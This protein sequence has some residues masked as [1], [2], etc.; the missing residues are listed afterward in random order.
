LLRLGGQ[1]VAEIGLCCCCSQLMS[2]AGRM[3]RPG[4]RLR[5]VPA[6][7][8]ADLYG[9]GERPGQRAAGRSTRLAGQ[10]VSRVHRR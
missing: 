6:C 4:A 9:H 10:V 8:L 5:R 2:A 1:G 3:R 7:G